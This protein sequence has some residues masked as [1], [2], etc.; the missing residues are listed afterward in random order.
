MSL[1]KWAEDN[2][3]NLCLT[4]HQ[5]V[6]TQPHVTQTTCILH[7]YPIPVVSTWYDISVNYTTGVAE[8]HKTPQ[9]I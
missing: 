6:N 1:E 4:E 5:V 7:E 3:L 8:V 2:R 9:Y